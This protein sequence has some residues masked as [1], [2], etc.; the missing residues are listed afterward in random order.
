MT[1]AD[2]LVRARASVDESERIPVKRY[3]QVPE[4]SQ[5]APAS[6]QP[7]PSRLRIFVGTVCWLLMA[8]FA[9]GLVVR[10]GH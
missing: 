5:D 9:V 4:M 10:F 6:A 8:A 7:R 3:G 1:P 2:D